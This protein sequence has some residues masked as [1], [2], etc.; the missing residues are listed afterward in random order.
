MFTAE[1]VITTEERKSEDSNV[2]DAKESPLT[3][4]KL[5]AGDILNMKFTHALQMNIS[6]K[7]A[8]NNIPRSTRN[9]EIFCDYRRLNETYNNG[10]EYKEMKED[11]QDTYLNDKSHQRFS[12]LIELIIPPI[13]KHT[14][15]VNADETIYTVIA[16]NNVRWIHKTSDTEIH[17][18][19][20]SN[21]HCTLKYTSQKER[22]IDY[23][24][25]CEL[26]CADAMYY[27][28][29]ANDEVNN[30]K[31][32]IRNN[33]TKSVETFVRK[34]MGNN[35]SQ[36][37]N[38]ADIACEYGS[39]DV[40]L[41]LYELGIN[42]TQEGYDIAAKNKHKTIVSMKNILKAK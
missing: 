26:I 10:I 34:Y 6:I 7:N 23:D 13:F 32:H 5:Q 20:G 18:C 41:C 35:Q 2:Y 17:I 40:L 31:E 11:C 1:K 4:I 19:G 39:I 33:D 37:I 29:I 24:K 8:R 38:L 14:Y 15:V 36:L 12:E 27:K 9:I 22:D 42:A 28:R 3:C 30:I 21:H 16:S 25:I